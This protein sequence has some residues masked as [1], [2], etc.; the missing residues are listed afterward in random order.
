[1][2]TDRTDANPLAGGDL[3]AFAAAVETSSVQGAADALQLTQ[4]AA[5][6]RIQSLERRVGGRLLERGRLGTR[7]TPL[8]RA[9]YPPAKRALEALADVAQVA[10]RS[11]ASGAM[12]LRLS[13][14]LT[15]GEF[16]LPGWLAEFRALHP[17]VHPQL[18]IVNSQGVL[19]AVREHQVEIGFVEGL[20]SLTGFEALTIARDRLVVVVAVDHRWAR[21]RAVAV[22][23]LASE[24]YLTREAAS[25]TRAVADA[26]LARADVQLQP[27]LQAASFQ[28]LKRSLAGGGF[29]LISELTIEAELRAGTL[30]G[31]PVRGA[32][33]TRDLSA[34]RLRRPALS[35]AARPFWRWLTELPR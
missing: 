35:G 12:D 17:D 13:A 10:E 9:I 3:A 30:V 32:D 28:S 18:E 11:R 23:E 27:S 15:V 26:A 7:P 5:T 4:S 2:S 8:G 25:G 6:K 31:I 24:P 21:R 34:I 22:R 33:L 20:D 29:A 14:S 19:V 16:L 1:M